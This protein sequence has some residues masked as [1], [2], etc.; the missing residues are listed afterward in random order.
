MAKGTPKHDDSGQGKRANQGRGGCPP[1]KQPKVG[2]GK[3]LR[4]RLS[5]GIGRRWGFKIPCP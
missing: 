3:Q 4:K 5:G 2:K 1:V